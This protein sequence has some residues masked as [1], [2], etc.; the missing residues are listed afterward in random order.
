MKTTTLK[1]KVNK[2]I[3]Y[4]KLDIYKTLFK[5]YMVEQIFGSVKNNKPTGIIKKFFNTFSEA[6]N[7]FIRY[8]NLKIKKGYKLI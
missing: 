7:Y 8:V 1:R 3:R 2:N 5:L 6:K 4:I